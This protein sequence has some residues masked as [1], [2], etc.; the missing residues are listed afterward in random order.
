M[1]RYSRRYSDDFWPPYVPVAERR[2]KAQKQIE[3][4]R[5][6]G[7][8]IAPIEI[9][10]R[11]IATTFWGEAWCDNLE[12]YSDYANRLPRGRTYVRNGSVIDL[13]IDAGKVR[14]LVSGSDI[15]EVA[16]TIQP[17]PAKQWRDI[18]TQCAGHIG[19]LVELLKG[20]FSKDV[21]EIVTRRGA[22]LFPTPK[23][24][25]FECSCPDWASMCKHVAAALY[26]VGAR[27]DHEPALLFTL[28]GVDPTEMVQTA[29][30][31]T[32]RT[33]QTQKAS[34]LEDKEL[35][36]LF[37]VEIDMGDPVADQASPKPVKK[38]GRP[39]GAKNKAPA[40]TVRPKRSAKANVETADE[41]TPV[42][43]KPAA[44]GTPAKSPARKTTTRAK[45]AET[46]VP[47][48]RV[49]KK[50]AA[51]ATSEKKKTTTSTRAKKPAQPATPA[52]KKPAAEK[53]VK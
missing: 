43:K 30:D 47:K 39:A 3:K 17:L 1:S 53:P 10:G 4:M 48:K 14:A 6:K 46:T 23:E 16:I 44:K 12:A 13:R 26:G 51:A 25:R 40:R 28:R 8:T 50:P 41:N 7:R 11:K 15:Y 52:K 27:L 35:S 9:S 45:V 42:R 2:Y 19:S 32:I 33:T 31:Q 20:A 37:G 18:K 24:I 5:K 34:R 38:R 21:M 49:P 36:S 22:G 29:I